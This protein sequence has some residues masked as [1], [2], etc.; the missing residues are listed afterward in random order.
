MSSAASPQLLAQAVATDPP[1]AES[2]DGSA[3]G[4]VHAWML[5]KGSGRATYAVLSLG[6]FMGLGKSYYPVPFELLG[7]DP[8][9]DVY[10]VRVD[11][12]LLKGGPSW[13]NHAPAFDAAYAERV[14]RYYGEQR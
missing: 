12:Q 13:A 6:G 5:D 9:R 4:T 3:I 10:V 14:A 11:P 8:V 1:K 2:R 7:Y